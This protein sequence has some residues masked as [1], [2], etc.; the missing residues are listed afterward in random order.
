[1]IINMERSQKRN[2][3]KEF[4]VMGFQPWKC[5]CFSLTGIHGINMNKEK[6]KNAKGFTV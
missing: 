6:Q 1:M 4:L 2:Q 5:L 3:G